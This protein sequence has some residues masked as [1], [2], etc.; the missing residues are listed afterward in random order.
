M[1]TP[2]AINNHSQKFF[3]FRGKNINTKGNTATMAEL[4]IVTAN[5]RIKTPH[6]FLFISYKMYAI[7]VIP[8]ATLCRTVDIEKKKEPHNK[9][10]NT[11]KYIQ[12]DF[13]CINLNIGY[14]YIIA[15]TTQKAFQEK[16]ILLKN[17]FKKENPNSEL[18]IST[19]FQTEE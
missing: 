10:I 4:C 5:G 14:I 12:S 16:D 9:N 3:L 13:F 2:P 11:L 18:L 17:I 8:I 1:T 15:K 6:F 7:I 19:S